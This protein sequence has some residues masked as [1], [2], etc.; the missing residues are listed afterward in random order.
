MTFLEAKQ[1]LSRKLDIDYSNISNNGLF[2][3]ADL[4][5]WVNLGV[6]DAWDFKPWPFTQGTETATT[7]SDMVTNGYAD[8]PQDLMNG[9]IYLLRVGGKEY[10]KLLIEDYLKYLEDYPSATDRI[11][12][13][14]ETFI[15][16]NKNA[17]TVGN[18]FDLYGRKMS[19]QLS[20]S[21]DI[22]PFS[23]VTDNQEHSGN[24]AIVLLANSYALDSEKKQKSDIAVGVRKEALGILKSL[25]KPYA[26]SKSYLQSKGRPMFELPDMLSD[27]PA[28]GRQ[29]NSQAIGN[30]TY[31]N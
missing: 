24:H 16:I 3:D 30:F 12:S 15:F 2:T 10:K 17:Y 22:L 7:T 25:W 5:A 20:A 29:S 4:G 9:S 11:W 23:P 6:I 8:H 18:T 1:E 19:P 14:H 26:Q 27:G 31:I 13:E 28:S 21:G